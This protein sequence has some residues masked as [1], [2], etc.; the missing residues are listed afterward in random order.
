[1]M[2]KSSKRKKNKK[3]T[4][5]KKKGLE[6]VFDY[7]R[8]VDYNLKEQVKYIMASDESK[9][10]KINK[11]DRLLNEATIPDKKRE[12][13]LEDVKEKL[14]K[15]K[16]WFIFILVVVTRGPGFEPGRP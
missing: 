1:M 6:M 4:D 3:K 11:V 15:E 8:R 10:Q 7:V 12:K 9:V 13:I 16:Y 2:G 14:E 5:S